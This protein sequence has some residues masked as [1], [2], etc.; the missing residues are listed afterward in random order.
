MGTFYGN[1]TTKLIRQVA[2]TV[3]WTELKSS[4][5]ASARLDARAVHSMAF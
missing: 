1:R 2:L 3:K 4:H 5:A